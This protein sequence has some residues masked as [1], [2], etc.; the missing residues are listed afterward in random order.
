VPTHQI[1]DAKVDIG[2]FPPDRSHLATMLLMDI[3]G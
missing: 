3:A 1:E 2:G